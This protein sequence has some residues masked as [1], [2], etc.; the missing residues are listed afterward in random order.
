MESFKRFLNA[1]TYDLQRL[2]KK[3]KVSVSELQK[4]LEMGMDVEREHTTHT[5][6]A[7]EIALDHLN[8]VPDYY[9]KLKHVEGK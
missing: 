7:R 6:V 1:P 9:S 3:H 4:Q 8:E 2:A 5:K